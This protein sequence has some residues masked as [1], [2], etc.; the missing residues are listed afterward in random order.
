V[1]AKEFSGHGYRGSIV[2]SEDVV[3]APHER[4]GMAWLTPRFEDVH[5][6]FC[7]AE[8]TY[9][10]KPRIA[11]ASNETFTKTPMRRATFTKS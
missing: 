5:S 10:G 3:T 8:H 4:L 2:D 1:D 6:I 7:H 11:G 9:C